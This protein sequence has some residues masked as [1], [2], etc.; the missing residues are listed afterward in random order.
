MLQGEAEPSEV[1]EMECGVH[2]C[3]AATAGEAS[4][5]SR[6]MQ[7][8]VQGSASADETTKKTRVKK[9][10][11]L[12]RRWRVACEKRRGV[13]EGAAAAAELHS[14]PLHLHSSRIASHPRRFR[15]CVPLCVARWIVT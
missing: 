6:L 13:E 11:E 14:T 10:R 5:A 12:E 1:G 15:V 8:Q 4:T 2:C 9:R 7:V 3:I